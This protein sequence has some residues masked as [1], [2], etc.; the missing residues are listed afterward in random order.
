MPAGVA[1]RCDALGL[2]F[3]ARFFEVGLDRRPDNLE[4]LTEL[5]HVYTKLGRYAEGLAIDRRI[6]VA[7]PDDPTAH[8]NLACSCALTGDPDGAF[9]ALDEAVE[10]GYGDVDL[11]RTDADLAALRADPRFEPLVARVAAQREDPEADSEDD[12]S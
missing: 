4:A 9:A 2:A 6:V 11:L 10:L 7:L 1:A 12:P 5:G 3:L 8:Y